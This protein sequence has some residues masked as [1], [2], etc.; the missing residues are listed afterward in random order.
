MGLVG[1]PV[2]VSGLGK[3]VAPPPPQKMAKCHHR[4][5]LRP[6]PPGT[7]A[8]PLSQMHV[9]QCAVKPY[10]G[11]ADRSVHWLPA[12]GLPRHPAP[13][14]T[15]WQI[16]M[17][18]HANAKDMCVLHIMHTVGERPT[19]RNGTLNSS[20][21]RAICVQQK[22]AKHSPIGDAPAPGSRP[23]TSGTWGSWQ[24]SERHAP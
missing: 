4:L 12:C 17:Q 15:R 13:S 21:S 22:H 1:L 23:P 10:A 14:P 6:R 9:D 19:Q 7:A 24:M 11:D 8:W 16:T 2:C 18:S 3:P 20:L 5:P